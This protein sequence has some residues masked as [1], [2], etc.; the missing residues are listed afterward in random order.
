MNA[1]R[2]FPA[3]GASLAALLF[4]SACGANHNTAYRLKPLA[5]TTDSILTI[6]AK[7]RNV[8]I[9]RVGNVA[10]MCAEP[11]P[12]V[13]SVFAQSLGA[14]ISGGTASPKQI[15]AAASLALS[16]AENG[17]TISRTQTSNVVREL[18][19]RT[20][21]R[22]LSGA[23]KEDEFAIQAIRDQRMVI[24]ILAIEQLTGAVTPPTVVIRA[25]GEADTGTATSET[26]KAITDAQKKVHTTQKAA[27][28]AVTKRDALDKEAPKC[29]DLKD[30]ETEASRKTKRASCVTA[31]AVVKSTKEVHD[32]AQEEYKVLSAAVTKGGLPTSASTTTDAAVF[33][34]MSRSSDAQVKDVTASINNIIDHVYG[35]DEFLLFCIGSMPSIMASTERPI[36]AEPES[37]ISTACETYVTAQINE[38]AK[39]RDPATY[40]SAQL[41]VQAR[42]DANF[43][44]FW[45]AVSNG[46]SPPQSDPAKVAAILSRYRSGNP[47]TPPRENELKAMAA[48]ALG[49]DQ[50]KALFSRLLPAQQSAFATKGDQK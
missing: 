21:E 29:A 25:S 14:S 42:D 20:C 13:F 3:T 22:Y 9:R 30:D 31:D 5:M 33:A 48:A 45:S 6:D 15:E 43:E 36:K 16:S 50:L 35:Q 4:L 24:S 28:D 47:G 18:M 12:D 49:K 8:L 1:K 17:A 23:I 46:A 40:L 44:S 27:T 7:Q 38:Q 26:V 32:T 11:S 2:R 19:F 34:G 41:A 39:M 10:R 37:R